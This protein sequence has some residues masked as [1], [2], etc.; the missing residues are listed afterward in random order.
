M[1]SRLIR[2]VMICLCIPFSMWGKNFHVAK[3]GNDS[4]A[5]TE[6]QP[7]QTIGRAAEVAYPG[8]MIIIHEGI[9]R[10]CIVPPRGGKS[11]KERIIYQAAEGEHVIVSGAEL[12]TDWKYVKN[13][14]WMLTLPDEYFG[15]MNPFDEQI[16]GSWYRGKG[17]PNH[18]GMVFL[19]DQRIRECFSMQYVYIIDYQ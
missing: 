10:E 4:N 14:T 5:G 2:M 15:E 16:Y 1:K 3:T 17:R 9:Y 7:F 8:D 19:N 18:T 11:D 13:N 6:E 12:A